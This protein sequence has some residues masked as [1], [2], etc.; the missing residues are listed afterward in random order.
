M[1]GLFGAAHCTIHEN[2]NENENETGT[3]EGLYGQASQPRL[4]GP[5]GE[6]VPQSLVPTL[7]VFPYSSFTAIDLLGNAIFP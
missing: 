4:D 6:Q 5:D 2:E 3:D 7:L 1:S